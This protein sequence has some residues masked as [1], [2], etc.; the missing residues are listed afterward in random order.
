M[1]ALEY[2]KAND[3]ST[4]SRPP[5]ISISMDKGPIFHHQKATSSTLALLKTHGVKNSWNL[6]PLKRMCMFISLQLSLWHQ[7]ILCSFGNDP[8]NDPGSEE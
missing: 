1:V 7:V 5:S 2:P 3:T 6:L 4:L 8:D